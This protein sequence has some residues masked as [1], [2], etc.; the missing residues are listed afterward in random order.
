MRRDAG[1]MQLL[2]DRILEYLAETSRAS[3]AA[4]VADPYVRASRRRVARR[5]RVLSEAGL[6]A[7]VAPRSRVYQVTTWGRRYLE[8]EID[9][10][11][12]P[13]PSRSTLARG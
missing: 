10:R 8:G 11:H 5:C 4:I 9:A 12:Q 2:D 3:P 6:I 1:W 7:P 13:R